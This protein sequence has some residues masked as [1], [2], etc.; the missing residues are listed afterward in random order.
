VAL[1]AGACNTP[2]DLPLVQHSSAAAADHVVTLGADGR[3]GAPCLRAWTGDTVE[4]RNLAPDVPTNVT[5]LGAPVELYSPS[6]VAP[7]NLRE[8]SEGGAVTRWSFWRHTF[9]RP[10]VYEYY[11]TNQGDP[12]RKVVDPYYG[13]VTFVGLSDDVATAVV[14]VE[15]PGSG[16][17]DNVCC[18]RPS[19]CPSQQCCDLV[20]KVC[21]RGSP[22]AAKC[23]GPPAHR[24]FDCTSGSDCGDAAC[25][26]DTHTCIP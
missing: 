1:L 2:P 10:G 11:D 16:L 15:E 23:E 22:A 21:R 9:A 7:Y 19:E 5:S 3:V 18:T 8:V 20:A 14:C 24:E 17:C 6:L 12:G 13:T 25:D 26:P 4:W